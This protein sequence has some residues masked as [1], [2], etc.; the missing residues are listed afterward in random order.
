MNFHDA[1]EPTLPAVPAEEPRERP[2][3]AATSGEVHETPLRPISPLGEGDRVE[4]DYVAA[5]IWTA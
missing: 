4:G 3:P 5:R 2:S 1:D